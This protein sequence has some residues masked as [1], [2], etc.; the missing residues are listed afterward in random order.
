M[1][2]GNKQQIVPVVAGLKGDTF[3]EIQSGLSSTD[4]VVV[5]TAATGGTGTAGST[6]RLPGGLGGAGGG[7]GGGGLGGGLGGGGRGGG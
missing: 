7:L 4:R 1:S 6:V 2:A 3:T 5:S